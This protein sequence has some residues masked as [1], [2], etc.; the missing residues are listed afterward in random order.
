MIKFFRKIRQN[1][2][3][4]NKTTKYFKYG[5][6]EILL[7]VIGILIA[8]QVNN[9]NEARLDKLQLKQLLL[10]IKKNIKTDI[11]E[12]KKDAIYR[13]TLRS[14]NRRA[15]AQFI[16]GNIDV[17]TMNEAERF[18]YE[19]YFIPNT[20]GYDALKSSNFLGKLTNSPLDSLLH[21]YYVGLD[22]LHEREVSF[23]TFIENVEYD[24]RT[25]FP[26]I[27]IS[28]IIRKDS[29]S[30]TEEAFILGSYQSNIFQAGVLRAATQGTRL[31]YNLI[32]TGKVLI[33]EIDLY[34]NG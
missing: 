5:I 9:W 16:Q 6:G 17:E 19:F 1:L 11:V 13:D 3:I 34:L 31:Y 10:T 26:A 27:K 2:L 25:K 29:L 28:N 20:S 21:N 33:K 30:K 14:N 23:N 18:F 12:L 15:R 32:E 4:E 7:V 24:Y 22:N 8:L